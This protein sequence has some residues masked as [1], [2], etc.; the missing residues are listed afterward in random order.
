MEKLEFKSVGLFLAALEE[1]ALYDGNGNKY[2]LGS[3]SLSDYLAV[4]KY[5]ING[6]RIGYYDI[7]TSI[8]GIGLFRTF[9]RK[10]LPQD[11][12]LVICCTDKDR[13]GKVI[14]FYDAENTATFRSTDGKRDGAWFNNYEV[15]PKNPETGLW[16]HPF[17]WAN[18]AVK[19]LKNT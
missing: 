13:F 3:S 17:T 10:P 19:K 4:E 5:D 9:T 11:K 6:R 16:D 8:H 1:G 7:L 12:D 2:K 15:I 18:D 14:R